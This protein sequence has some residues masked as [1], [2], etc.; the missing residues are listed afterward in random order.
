MQICKYKNIVYQDK[1]FSINLID[2]VHK[3]CKNVN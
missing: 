2:F 3:K 1:I